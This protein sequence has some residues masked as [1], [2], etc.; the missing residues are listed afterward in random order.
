MRH[1]IN[2]L[3]TKYALSKSLKEL[4]SKSGPCD[5]IT[6]SDIVENCAVNRN[7]FYYH[8]SDV[9]DLLIWT[10]Q[11]D[12]RQCWGFDCFNGKRIR[13]FF[14]DYINNNNKLLNYAFQYLGFD[15]LRKTYNDELTVMILDY[16]KAIEKR[17][18]LRVNMFF[19]EFVSKLYA[20]SVVIIFMMCFRKPKEY[21]KKTATKYFEVI[22]DY[23]IPDMLKREKDIKLIFESPLKQSI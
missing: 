13:E 6:V 8:F 1:V 12:I 16:I 18:G 15:D 2:S 17:D 11:H 22:F 20:D 9:I 5:K 7:T 23:A 21:D 14:I 4:V 19:K 10:L 3:N